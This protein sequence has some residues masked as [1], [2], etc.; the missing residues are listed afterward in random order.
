MNVLQTSRVHPKL[1]ADHVLKGVHDSNKKPWL[2]PATRATILNPP[3]VRA[4]W[5]KRVLD[6][7]Y[8]G[9]AW[10]H[11]RALTFFVP[12]TGGTGVSVNSQLYPE[13]CDALKEKI[14]G[15]AVRVAKDLL[16]TIKKLQGQELVQPGR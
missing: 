9:P 1:P 16:N 5:D 12:S 14:V 7:W 3:N 4:S 2:P 15:D 10:D 6:A 8:V 11:Y 13:H